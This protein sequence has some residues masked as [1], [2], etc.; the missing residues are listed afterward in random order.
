MNKYDVVT[1]FPEV[2]SAL[3]S[4]ILKKAIDNNLFRV[5]L[6]QIRDFS[7]ISITKPTITVSA[8]GRV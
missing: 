2:F 4:G 5:N 7:R 3:D 6:T 1:L 8:G